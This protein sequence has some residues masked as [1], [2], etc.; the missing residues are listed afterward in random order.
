[1]LTCSAAAFGSTR[2]GLF[3]AVG[4][5]GRSAPVLL[6]RCL[7]ARCEQR[8][9]AA[10][11]DRR[12]SGPGP[13]LSARREGD[14]GR[15]GPL[16]SVFPR[17]ACVDRG[18]PSGLSH[19]LDRS[20]RRSHARADDRRPQLRELPRVRRHVAR[21]ARGALR[22]C[23]ASCA[24]HGI[25]GVRYA[26]ERLRFDGGQRARERSRREPLLHPRGLVGGGFERPTRLRDG[27]DRGSARH[28]ADSDRDAVR[29]FGRGRVAAACREPARPAAAVDRDGAADRA[30]VRRRGRV[31]GLPRRRHLGSERAGRGGLG[32]HPSARRFGPRLERAAHEVRVLSESRSGGSARGSSQRRSTNAT[33]GSTRGIPASGAAIIA[34]R[35]TSG[36]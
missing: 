5:A 19:G 6:E 23:P 11:S 3:H 24:A 4:G 22:E 30:C 31:H 32:R 2:R 29:A 18:L 21:A 33:N 10:S 13:R 8:R 7:L 12:T 28:R 34:A 14:A 15:R 36:R 16:R 20:R 1:M 17:R 9:G 35:C 25:G 26:V 27:A